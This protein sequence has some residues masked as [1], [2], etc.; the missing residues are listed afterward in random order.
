[1]ANGMTTLTP[2]QPTDRPIRGELTLTAYRPPLDLTFDEW[3]AIGATLQSLERSVR[4]WIGDWLA[5]GE[6][7]YGETYTQAVDATG[8]RVEDLMTMAWVSRAV[9]VS[10]RSERLSGSHHRAIAPLDRDQQVE[11]LK[12][13]ELDEL[14]VTELRQ[15]LRDGRTRPLHHAATC[16]RCGRTC[17]WCEAADSAK[18]VRNDLVDTIAASA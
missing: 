13:A 14:T 5:H 2:V 3:A 9:D 10:I 11:W 16:S 12:R 8:R 7:A 4:W 1:M 18:K 6:R 17:T 15:A